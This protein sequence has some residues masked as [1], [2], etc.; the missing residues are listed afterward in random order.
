[1]SD[2]NDILAANAAFY[3]AFAAGDF[4]ALA[5]LWADGDGISCIH[6]GWPAIVGRNAVIGSWRDILSNP[7]RPQIVCAEPHAIV[8]RDHGHVVCLEL[9]DGAALAAANH[10]ARSGGAWRM[11]HHQSS[12]IAQMISPDDNADGRSLH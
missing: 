10:F 7:A 11:V 12:A 4:A 8:D 2:A 9:V 3:A 5:A 1:M 6:P